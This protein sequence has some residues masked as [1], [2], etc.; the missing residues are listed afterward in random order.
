MFPTSIYYIYIFNTFL[1]YKTD[2][3]ISVNNVDNYTPERSNIYI[4]FDIYYQT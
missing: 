4:R 3:H 2:L 1:Q